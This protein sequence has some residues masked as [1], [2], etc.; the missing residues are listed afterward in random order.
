MNI[1]SNLP[2]GLHDKVLSKRPEFFCTTKKFVLMTSSIYSG[3]FRI[4]D[5]LTRIVYT[6]RYAPNILQK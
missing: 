2:I 1:L 3:N 6:V 5:Y 4:E